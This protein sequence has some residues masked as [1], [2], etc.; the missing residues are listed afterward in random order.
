MLRNI[1][2][3]LA[4]TGNMIESRSET[5]EV[6]LSSILKFLFSSAIFLFQLYIPIYLKGIGISG[7][8]IGVLTSV[9]TISALFLSAPI[10]I[11]NDKFSSKRLIQL[12]VFGLALFIT[13]F[14]WVNTFWFFIFI[15]LLGGIARNLF[16]ISARSLVMKKIG[17]GGQENNSSE[18]IG[19]F[20]AGGHLA[21]GVTGALGGVIISSFGFTTAFVTALILTLFI[22]IITFNMEDET[23]EAET[24]DYSAYKGDLLN[25]EFLVIAV[26]VTGFGFHAGVEKTSFSLFLKSI[27]VVE[28]KMGIIL[29]MIGFTMTFIAIYSGRLIDRF[30][31]ESN[32]GT[33]K[34][35]FIAALFLSAIGNIG[36]A[37]AQGFYSAFFIRFL[38]VVGDS[39]FFFFF[40]FSSSDIFSLEKYGGSSGIII[41]LFLS[42]ISI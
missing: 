9:F 27:G 19:I 11:W 38:H 6:Y 20:N 8:Q 16:N 23:I 32:K 15:F 18:K 24:L 34:K 26:L 41:L 14:I 36:F 21:Y 22:F 31:T 29:A 4:N 35:F 28:S 7:G 1:S 40:F 10:G 33:L 3:I 30:S 17:D 13:G 25:R 5:R 39:V 42:V 37:Y 12:S 2:N